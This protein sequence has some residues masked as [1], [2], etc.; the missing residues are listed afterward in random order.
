MRATNAHNPPE[1]PPVG[2][3]VRKW[4]WWLP[5]GSIPVRG[6]HRKATHSRSRPSSMT[7]RV[8]RYSALSRICWA[9]SHF[10]FLTPAACS[11]KLHA[12]YG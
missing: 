5:R 1:H 9:Q 2:T 4:D 7:M 3:D 12:S 6:Q 11:S 8:L 10:A